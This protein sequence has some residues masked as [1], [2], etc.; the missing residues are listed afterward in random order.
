MRFVS[1]FLRGIAAG[2]STTSTVWEPFQRT[3]FFLG[4]R[5]RVLKPASVHAGING[6]YTVHLGANGGFS[7]SILD[8]ASVK[9]T[10]SPIH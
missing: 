7:D 2:H 1:D 4:F 9:A 6:G 10:I 3:S 8:S 5:T